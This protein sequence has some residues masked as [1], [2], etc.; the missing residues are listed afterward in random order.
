MLKNSSNNDGKFKRDRTEYFKR[1]ITCD[2]CCSTYPVHLK[3]RHEMTEKH[4]ENFISQN[5]N[6]NELNQLIKSRDALNLLIDLT[7]K[8][9]NMKSTLQLSPIIEPN[10]MH[11]IMRIND[12]ISHVVQK[13][14]K[15]SCDISQWERDIIQ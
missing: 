2:L 4:K 5:K 14:G 8:K 3:G 7:I 13:I 11:D 15:Q 1:K 10:V 12:N 6:D 9:K